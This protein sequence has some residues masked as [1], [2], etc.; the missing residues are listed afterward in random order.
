MDQTLCMTEK[1]SYMLLGESLKE[2]YSGCLLGLQHNR[3][4]VKIF[5]YPIVSFLF[6]LSIYTFP[7]SAFTLSFPF[8][9]FMGNGVARVCL[10]E[11]KTNMTNRTAVSHSSERFG[12]RRMAGHCVFVCLTIYLSSIIIIIL[13]ESFNLGAF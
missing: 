11:P 12:K 6:L 13:H 2:E 7:M 4:N 10:S 5:C 1:F 3:H 8:R 9:H